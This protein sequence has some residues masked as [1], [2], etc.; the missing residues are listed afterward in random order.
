LTMICPPSLISTNSDF[1]SILPKLPRVRISLFEHS[2]M[3]SLNRF[4]CWNYLVFALKK[5][6]S[7][8]KAFSH[9]SPVVFKGL[10]FKRFLQEILYAMIPIELLSITHW[11]HPPR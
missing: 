6:T 7:V 1:L 5:S 4:H 3:N 9:Y 10:R 2:S 8:P 11:S